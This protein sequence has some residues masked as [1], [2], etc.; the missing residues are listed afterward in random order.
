MNRGKKLK[1]GKEINL[2]EGSI[3]RGLLLFVLPIIAG[4][5][6]QQLYIAADAVI[7]GQFAGKTGLAA[8]DSVH[9]LFKFPLNFMSGLSAGATIVISGYFG[10]KKYDDLK[11]SART[12]YTLAAIL[13][14][15][16]SVAGVLITPQLLELMDVPL[17]IRPMT[18]I[19]CR[20]YFGG[21]WSMV[22]Y[23]MAA[24]VLRALGDSKNPL[25]ILMVCSAVNIAGDLLLVGVFDMGVGGAA[26]ATVLAQIV[27]A[28]CALFLMIRTVHG[29]ADSHLLKPHYCNIHM[30]QMVKKG[31]PLAL[32]GI[33]FPIANS[34][35]QA[36]VNGMGTDAIA[37]W[38]ICGKLDMLIWLIADAMG[39]AMTTYTAQ[40]LGAGRKD[41]VKK[42]VFAG[43]GI[44]VFSIA[45]I[46]A[47]LYAGT[48]VL[49]C[50]FIA[51]ADAAAIVP[52]AAHYMKLMAPF[53]VFYGV[54]E[55][56]SG[57]CCGMGDTVHPMILTLIC[58]CLLRVLA[59]WFVLPRFESMECIIG[60]YIVSWIASGTAF[61]IMYLNKSRRELAE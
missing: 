46:S 2:I 34:I 11:C 43:G 3:F 31:M 1:K 14:V 4:S 53:Y 61:T 44:A 45:L 8:I 54:Y 24:G 50:L 27:S 39:P 17:D 19:Y 51:K 7:V 37:A 18:A 25:Y 55:I 56:C 29:A 26:A 33:L 30:V 6:I 32:Q 38:S 5:L 15:I 36:S 9:T 23:N 52:I 58:T 20:I 22:L 13:G 16:C 59:I 48:P 47:V 57:T 35:V 42:G 40:N 41:R 49:G 12:A 10:A 28:A 60:I 21:I